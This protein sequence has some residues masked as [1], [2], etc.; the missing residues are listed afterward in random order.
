MLT[1]QE[2]TLGW[3]I[4]LATGLVMDARTKNAKHLGLITRWMENAIVEE[5]TFLLE[6]K[7]AVFHE[8][9]NT[10]FTIL[11]TA[12]REKREMYDC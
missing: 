7:Y 9:Q 8:C 1:R 10:D 6:L 11:Y 12:F 5:H 3:F 2:D 4:R